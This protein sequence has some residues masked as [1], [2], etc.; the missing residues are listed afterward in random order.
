MFFLAIFE[1]WLGDFFPFIP[2]LLLLRFTKI[3]RPWQSSILPSSTCVAPLFEL[4]LSYQCQCELSLP[5]IDS[6]QFWISLMLVHIISFNHHK[7]LRGS[8]CYSHLTCEQTERCNG[9][10]HCSKLLSIASWVRVQGLE[11]EHLGLY[12]GSKLH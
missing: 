8:V 1:G 5:L 2:C 3:N 7:K 10:V 12:L 4:S 11:P 9:Q 6:D